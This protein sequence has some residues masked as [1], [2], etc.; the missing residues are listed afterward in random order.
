MMEIEEYGIIAEEPGAAGSFLIN[1]YDTV[2]EGRD[3]FSLAK[4]SLGPGE[5]GRW[6]IFLVRLRREDDGSY[7]ATAVEPEE[8]VFS[9]GKK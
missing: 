1:T 9:G 4:R 7:S 3:A 6:R 8:E 2:G 5:K